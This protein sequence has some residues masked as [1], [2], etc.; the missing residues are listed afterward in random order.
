MYLSFIDQLLRAQLLTQSLMHAIHFIC[1]YHTKY[2][3]LEIP[4]L[5]STQH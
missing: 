3:S 1:E 5:V 4:V 2:S